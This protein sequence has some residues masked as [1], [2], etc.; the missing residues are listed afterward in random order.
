MC[1]RLQRCMYYHGQYYIW[2]IR[3][4]RRIKRFFSL[5]FPV[6]Q[7]SGDVWS[8]RYVLQC[9]VCIYYII[10]DVK[11]RASREQVSVIC[12]VFFFLCTNTSFFSRNNNNYYYTYSFIFIYTGIIIRTSSL[13]CYIIIYIFLYT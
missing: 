13:A 8:R 11:Q 9:I 5:Y 10:M 12:Y 2:Y 7:S 3:R 4:I 1:I 6:G